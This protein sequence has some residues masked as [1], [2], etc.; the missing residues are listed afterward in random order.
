MPTC[1]NVGDLRQIIIFEQAH[2]YSQSYNS[3]VLPQQ[4]DQQILQLRLEKMKRCY[5]SSK[6]YILY[7]SENI[8]KSIAL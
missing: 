1:V 5:Q 7:Q 2:M 3:T 4:S 8:H 6:Q